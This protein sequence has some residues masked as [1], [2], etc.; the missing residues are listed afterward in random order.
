M[1]AQA[2]PAPRD[3]RPGEPRPQPSAGEL[4][5]WAALLLAISLL[6]AAIAIPLLRWLG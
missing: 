1:R 6:V 5:R 3:D 2:D 4:F